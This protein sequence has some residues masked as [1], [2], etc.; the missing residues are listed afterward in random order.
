[1]PSS[2]RRHIQLRA[3][4]CAWR[5]SIFAS[6]IAEVL[7]AAEQIEPGDFESWY[8]AFYKLAGQVKER[9]KTHLIGRN[10]E[11]LDFYDDWGVSQS[12]LYLLSHNANNDDHGRRSAIR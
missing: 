7:A 1:M 12:R 10:A 9:G 8:S 3:A 2:F 6:D 11:L 4:P 5:R